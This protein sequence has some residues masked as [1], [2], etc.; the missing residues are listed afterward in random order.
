MS[1]NIC[2]EASKNFIEFCLSNL[3]KESIPRLN[4]VLLGEFI[5]ENED[6]EHK[7]VML[8]VEFLCTQKNI[9]Y[10]D[11]VSVMDSREYIIMYTIYYINNIN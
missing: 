3:N 7:L 8:F 5:M 10:T 6:I 9:S 2:E 4:H 1:T 11:F